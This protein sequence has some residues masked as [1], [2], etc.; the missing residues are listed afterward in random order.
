MT[1]EQIKTK[2]TIIFDHMDNYKSHRSW[3]VGD[4]S[5]SVIRTKDFEVAVF[6]IPSGTRTEPHHHEKI[7]ETNLIIQGSCNLTCD[8]IKHKLKEGDIFTFPP[9][10]ISRCKYTSDTILL[11]IKTPQIPSDKVLEPQEDPDGA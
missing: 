10:V 7:I 6:R 9:S 4:F 5:P 2:K 1:P 3:V 8:G 11:C